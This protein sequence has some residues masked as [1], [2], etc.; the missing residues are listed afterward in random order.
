MFTPYNPNT[1]HEDN[2][3]LW[4]QEAIAKARKAHKEAHEKYGTY[5]DICTR[6]LSDYGAGPYR[7]INNQWHCYECAASHD[8]HN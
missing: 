7:K 8:K 5:C 2:Q 6:D 4:A 1:S 3:K